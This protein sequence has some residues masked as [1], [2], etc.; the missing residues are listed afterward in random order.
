MD[1]HQRF[2]TDSYSRE[3]GAEVVKVLELDGK[4][5]VVLSDTILFP[6]GGGQPGDRGTVGNAN[7]LDVKVVQGEIVHILDRPLGQGSVTV[8]LDWERRFDNMQQHTGQHLLTAVAQDKFG[9]ATT[10]FHLGPE[11]CDIELD[12]SKISQS[13]RQE[14]EEAVIKE[15]IAS[16]K[17]GIA[18]VSLEEYGS[19][20]VRS[21]GLPDGHCGDVRLVEIEGLDVNTCG[22]THL[23]STSELECIKLIDVEPIRGGTRLF[24]V[25]G[26]RLR[27]RL[28]GHEERNRQ[29][30]T[31]LGRPDDGL[32]E[33]VELRMAHEKELE[34]TLRHTEDDLA[35]ASAKSLLAEPGFLLTNHF[36]NKD[37]GFLQKLVRSI[38]E[39]DPSRLVFV[40]SEKSN[41]AFFSLA[42]GADCQA[43]VPKLGRELAAILNG[44]G[45]GSGRQFQGKFTE[46]TK[47]KEARAMLHQAGPG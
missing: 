17:V 45:G 34:R 37:A 9:W 38:L 33:A 4:P 3:L 36:E 35:T 24:F 27:A 23:A 42:A 2:E 19:M 5:C 12:A 43:D 6:E 13:N 30:R 32:V 18:W 1:K 44:K 8:R 31:I 47:L 40:T 29:L 20:K 7:V 39:A 15:I 41:N 11:L 25:F 21:R 14:L 46:T 26:K 28:G 10:A 22:G 16:R